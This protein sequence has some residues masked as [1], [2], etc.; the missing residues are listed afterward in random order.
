M[1]YNL[2][3]KKKAYLKKIVINTRNKYLKKAKYNKISELELELLEDNEIIVDNSLEIN[4]EIKL[5][6]EIMPFFIENI[7][8]DKKIMKIVKTLSLREKLVLFLY[9]FE[10]KTDKSIGKFLNVNGDTITKIRCRALKK[11]RKQY[12]MKGK[13]KNV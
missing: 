13:E 11:I 12:Y 3:K 6:K 10:S 5:D 7:F 2:K 4:L 9:Y 1:S 8:T